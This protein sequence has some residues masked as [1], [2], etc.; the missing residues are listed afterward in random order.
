LIRDG[1]TAVCYDGQF[2]YDTDHVD[3]GA[4]F[5]TNQD[6]DITSAAVA[7]A[8]PTDIEF[9]NAVQAIINQ[10]YGFK[11]NEGDPFWPADTVAGLDLGILIPT[12][13]IEIAEQVE[14]SELLT[15]TVSNPV[16]GKFTP[17]PNPYFAAASTT[18][19]IFGFVRTHP[20]KAVI[21]QVAD[22]LELDDDMG[23]DNEFD[24]KD[25]AFG[26]FQYSNA[27]YGQWRTTVRCEF[28]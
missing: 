17:I 27:G 25:V 2:F 8:T 22:D 4:R 11:D 9:K 5:T 16:K 10:L 3:V 14:S 28:T 19:A 18:P 26:T 20:Q 1:H 15:G 13:Y 7:T 6:N 23:G 24:T 12:A 21:M